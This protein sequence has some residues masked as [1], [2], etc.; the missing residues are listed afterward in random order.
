MRALKAGF[1]VADTALV[2][3]SGRERS[4]PR[5]FD[6]LGPHRLKAR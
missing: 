3:F 5:R 2:T 1:R 4:V 6:Q